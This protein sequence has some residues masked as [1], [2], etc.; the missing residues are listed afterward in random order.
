MGADIMSSFISF[1][2]STFWKAIE[3]K[4]Y[5]LLKTCIVNSIRNNPGFKKDFKNAKGDKCSEA[6]LA[7]D[8][9]KEKVPEIFEKYELQDGEHIYDPNEAAAWDKEYFIRQTFLLKQNFCTKR[10]NHVKEIGIKITHEANSNFQNPQEQGQMK[11]KNQLALAR[12]NQILQK[13][14]PLLVAGAV[15]IAVIL[16]VIVLVVLLAVIRLIMSIYVI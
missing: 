12:I 2:E 16:A 14:K 3:E 6:R 10:Y 7:M 9:L 1:D 11:R 8:I 4:N 5:S 15:V 13:T